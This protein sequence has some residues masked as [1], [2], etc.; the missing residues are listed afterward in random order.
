LA[1]LIDN[2][3]K[4]SRGATDP[5]IFLRVRKDG[6]R[7]LI[8]EVQDHGPGVS[9]REG[10]SIF[11]PFRRGRDA[12]VTAGGA[13]LGLALAQ[14]WAGLLGGSLTLQGGSKDTGACFR[15]ELPLSSA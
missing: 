2:A 1:N 6:H 11:R 12:E 10:R 3:C 9:R 13:G 15:L 7:R 8:M 14:R 5:R 4:Y